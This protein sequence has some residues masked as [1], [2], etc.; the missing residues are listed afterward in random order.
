MSTVTTSVYT[1]SSETWRERRPTS[2][3][4]L[5]YGA[6]G[7]CSSTGCFRPG[8]EPVWFAHQGERPAGRVSLPRD[9][10]AL[11]SQNGPGCFRAPGGE[12]G[13]FSDRPGLQWRPDLCPSPAYSGQHHECQGP[14][15]HL[16]LL[17]LE[18]KTCPGRGGSE[19]GGLIPSEGT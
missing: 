5:G 6:V 9:R 1:V 13:R 8:V 4:G 7:G 17:P 14:F 18:S 11:S 15:T 16:P 19:G 10:C 3:R 12:A 2:G